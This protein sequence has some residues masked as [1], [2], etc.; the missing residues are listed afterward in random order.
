MGS[1]A[2][3]VA[4]SLAVLTTTTDCAASRLAFGTEQL[5]FELDNSSQEN[6]GCLVGL[7]VASDPHPTPNGVLRAA[8]GA[9]PIGGATQVWRL[10]ATAC[11]ASFPAATLAL[12]SCTASC[13]RKYVVDDDG[14]PR[15]ALLSRRYCIRKPRALP[16]R[17]GA[18]R[19]LHGTVHSTLDMYSTVMSTYIGTG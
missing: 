7:H 16:A 10:T 6:W 15:G 17:L 8:G 11:N 18:A 3:F 9:T 13:A 12:D 19:G 4:L 2:A 1:W 14:L 5:R